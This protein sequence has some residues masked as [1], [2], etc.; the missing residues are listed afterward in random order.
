[1]NNNN[2]NLNFTNNLKIDKYLLIN[3]CFKGNIGSVINIL[4]N[5]YYITNINLKDKEGDTALIKAINIKNKEIVKILCDNGA[6]VNLKD[7]EGN[8]PL[9]YAMFKLK[10]PFGIIN[11]VKILEI[12]CN[13]GADVNLHS[14]NGNTPLMHAID[15][16][17]FLKF[18]WEEEDTELIKVINIKEKEIV[19]ILCDNGADVNLKDKEGDTALIRA[20]NIK[21]KETVKILCDNGADVNL[22]NK[23]GKTPLIYAMIKLKKPMTS[24]F[25]ANVNLQ[26]KNRNTRLINTIK[27]KNNEILEI[28]KIVKIVQILCDN[29][30]DVNLPS[31]NGNT[32]LMYA[33][34]F[35]YFLKFLCDYGADVNYK[36][37][38][39]DTALIC[40]IKKG[41]LEQ[42]KFLCDNGADVNLQNNEGNTALMYGIKYNSIEKIKI[43][44]ECGADVNCKNIYGYT[45][46]DYAIKKR[47]IDIIKILTGFSKKSKFSLYELLF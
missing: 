40:G 1:M 29:G 8:T 46:L 10:N 14:D 3:E 47:N 24:D 5:E 37:R 43:L 42:I 34:Y 23:E 18:L 6:D 41:N 44:Y 33:I 25:I 30:A 17:F 9:I 39:G 11:I 36:N 45:P 12:L 32:P 7:K 31:D 2:K 21:N 13:Y 20:I 38:H 35:N 26:I 16:I 19:K 4:K 27:I 15:I 28:V 22:K